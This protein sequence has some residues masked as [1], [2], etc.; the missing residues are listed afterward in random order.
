V[1]KVLIISFL[2]PFFA[3]GQPQMA[4][5]FLGKNLPEL[6]AIRFSKIAN[7][8]PSELFSQTLFF[9][10][11]RPAFGEILGGDFLKNSKIPAAFCA[12]ELPFFCKI[13]FKMDKKSATPIRI[14]L[15]SAAYVDYL[16]G[17]T[18]EIRQ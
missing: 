2:A 5:S 1:R 4:T 3:F 12:A 11:K 17:K 10:K 14:R 15:G 8:T 16:E 13:E 6:R 9:E 7:F 18:R